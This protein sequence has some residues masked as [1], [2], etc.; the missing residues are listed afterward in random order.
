MKLV[1]ISI[2]VL[3]STQSFAFEK[4]DSMSDFKSALQQSNLEYS[5]QRDSQ[6]SEADR[7]IDEINDPIVFNR[8]TSKEANQ[9]SE[10]STLN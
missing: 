8:D 6:L 3:F 4:E 9:N 10:K 2:I 7:M 5:V 1:T